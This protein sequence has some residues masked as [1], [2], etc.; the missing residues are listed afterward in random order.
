MTVCCVKY[1]ILLGVALQYPPQ[2]SQTPRSQIQGQIR[3]ILIY[4]AA[5]VCVSE[6]VHPV[7]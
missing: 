4:K 1:T 5:C 6:S 7:I 3:H 2:P